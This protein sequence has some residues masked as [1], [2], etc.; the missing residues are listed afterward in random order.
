MRSLVFAAAAT[1]VIVAP[2]GSQAQQVCRGD[3]DDDSVVTAADVDALVA[4][5]FQ[6]SAPSP[7][8]DVNAD[9]VISAA[10]LAAVIGLQGVTCAGPTHTRT[11]TRTVSSTPTPTP[12][13]SPRPTATPTQ[14]CTVQPAHFGTVSGALTANDC[15]RNFQG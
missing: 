9:N 1:L 3:V 5:L 6:D 8:A 7:R 15:L 10:D 12:T 14:V 11:E 2:L 4:T 13:Q